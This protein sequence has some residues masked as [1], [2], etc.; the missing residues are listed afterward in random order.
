M[1][2]DL[3]FLKLNGLLAEAR[4]VRERTQV[5]CAQTAALRAEAETC[6]AQ[7]RAMCAISVARRWQEP[8]ALADHQ[9]TA[10]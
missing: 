1:S 9:G 7:A 2:A 6:R 3:S 4:A 8:A 10:D 5:L